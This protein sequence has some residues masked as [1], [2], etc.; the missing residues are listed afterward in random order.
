MYHYD[1]TK[2]EG[3]EMRKEEKRG[4]KAVKVKE[5]WEGKKGGSVYRET[6]EYR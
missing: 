5:V 6:K 3:R 4:R 1:K 2:E